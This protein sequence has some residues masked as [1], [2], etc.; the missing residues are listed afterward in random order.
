MATRGGGTRARARARPQQQL[1]LGGDVELRAGESESESV[2]GSGG[3]SVEG[4]GEG[5]VGEGGKI[6]GRRVAGTGTGA[7]RREGQGQG[8]GRAEVVE[9]EAEE[10]RK[11]ADPGAWAAITPASAAATTTAPPQTTAA[12]T[13][14][15]PHLTFTSA[16]VQ[17]DFTTMVTCP[18]TNEVFVDPVV[19]ADGNTYEREAIQRW[20]AGSDRSPLAG[21]QLRSKELV[22]NH[23]LRHVVELA[24]PANAR[25]AARKGLA[26]VAVAPSVTMSL[27]GRSAS[28]GAGTGTGTTTTT[29]TSL[30]GLRVLSDTLGAARY[31]ISPFEPP[32]PGTRYRGSFEQT[33]HDGSLLA[34]SRWDVGLFI[35]DVHAYVS[36]TADPSVDVTFEW[37]KH[38][39]F[40]DPPEVV[41]AA[42]GMLVASG[43]ATG[44]GAGATSANATTST[45][46]MSASFHDASTRSWVRSLLANVGRTHQSRSRGVFKRDCGM[47]DLRAFDAPGGVGGGHCKLLVSGGFDGAGGGDRVDGFYFVSLDEGQGTAV[48]NGLGVFRMRRVV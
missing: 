34:V 28:T 23:A 21:V 18:I 26:T 47:L 5:E 33:F 24:F 11:C 43:A 20:L 44:A 1:G 4:E 37:R 41:A 31:A 46:T 39:Q 15:T 16:R 12:T 2:S 36:E 45:A 9:V 7:R 22:P 29:A 8:Q 19:A 3:E 17:H 38:T 14:A 32:A 48:V 27:T 30:P 42:T 13:Q 25:P 40:F 6:V 35:D 10:E